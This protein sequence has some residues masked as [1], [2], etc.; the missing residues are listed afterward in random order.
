MKPETW[1]LIHKTFGRFVGVS[2]N[3]GVEAE[4]IDQ[5]TASAATQLTSHVPDRVETFFNK[6]PKKL[7]KETWALEF[8]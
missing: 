6:L 1:Y 4:L 8:L 7:V 5:R 2:L 3:A